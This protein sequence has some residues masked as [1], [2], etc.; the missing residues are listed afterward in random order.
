[1]GFGTVAH[2]SG[3]ALVL[4]LG[5]LLAL[6]QAAFAVQS[7]SFRLALAEVVAAQPALRA[8]YA[9]RDYQPIWTSAAD[10]ERRQALFWALAR[11]QDHG[12]PVGRYEG[13]ALQARFDAATHEIE[14]AGLEAAMSEAFVAYARDISSG[15]TE[16]AQIDADFVRRPLRPAP[17]ALLSTFAEAQ[18]GPFLRQL[19]PQAP[20]Y[21]QLIRAKFELEEAIATEGWGP[22][23]PLQ[24]LRPGSVGPQVVALRDR[25][26][27]LGYL[28]RSVQASYD[29]ALRAA[30][31]QFQIDHGL[32]PD[33]I[34]GENTLRELNRSPQE[35]LRAVVVALE[36][37]R[38][39]NGTD[40]GTRHIWVN[41]PDYTAK[42]ID[43]GKVTFETVSVIGMNQ[44]G[45]RTPEFSDRMTY[46][47]INP[48]WN[49]PRSI[50]VQEY[51]P[52]LQKDPQ[53]A[54]YMRIIDSHGRVVPRSLVNFAQYTARSF[55][56]ALQQPPSQ[57]N[58]LGLVKFMFP[59]P[60]NI[61][62]HDTPQK[63]LFSRD[64]RAFSHGCIRLGEPFEFA[65][66]LLAAQSPDPVALFAQ[67]LQTGRETNVSLRQPVPVHLVY[68]TAWPN[69][70]G[71]IGFRRDVY[72]RDHAIFE[73]LQQA[74]VVLHGE[75]G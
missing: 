47:A 21:A 56:Y 28:G 72:G 27:A 67:H 4:A 50:T 68:F 49:V 14:L 38:W 33:G 35:R 29:E 20:Q 23:V 52:L 30:V 60:H 10:A 65:Y 25:L 22:E 58:A 5:C 2:R 13:A 31:R 66:A 7:P 16:P 53:A 6:A 74:G 61:Y 12:L 63:A 1:M 40:L 3:L 39:M 57:D 75:Q 11:A 9:A 62:L 59:N 34:A 71:K 15:V 24:V 48:S 42:I 32:S 69:P 37:L 45:M 70:K 41:L 55:P 46:M 73:A 26:H 19:P 18:P 36:R 44:T 51:L 43:D 8:F 64:Q 17:Q 54:S